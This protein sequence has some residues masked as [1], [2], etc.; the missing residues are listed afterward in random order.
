MPWPF[1][2]PDLID[3]QYDIVEILDWAPT[4]APLLHCC[5]ASV[6]SRH[7]QSQV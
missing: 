7:E 3:T 2:A 4:S 1:Y 6:G 5:P